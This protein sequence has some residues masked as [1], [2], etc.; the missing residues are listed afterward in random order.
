[1]RVPLRVRMTLRT[2]VSIGMVMLLMAAGNADDMDRLQGVWGLTNNHWGGRDHKNGAGTWTIQ[3]DN[4]TM[5]YTSTSHGTITLDPARTP[6]RFERTAAEFPDV[7]VRGTYRLEGDTLRLYSAMLPRFEPPADLPDE[8]ARGYELEVWKRV[9]GT[10]GDGFD[11]EWKRVAFSLAGK[12]DVSSM[13]GEAVMRVRGDTYQI[14]SAAR[15]R[16]TIKV[17]PTRSP[18]HIDLTFEADALR[19]R[20]TEARVYR[21]DGDKLMVWQ[22]AQGRPAEASDAADSKGHFEV[23]ERVKP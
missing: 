20:H 18:K 2:S 4:L 10:R 3:G 9:D 6:G 13:M 17:D 11:G 16:C 1:M 19:G 22:S 8:P 5:A 12:R 21:L 14:T 23:F 15:R 7:K